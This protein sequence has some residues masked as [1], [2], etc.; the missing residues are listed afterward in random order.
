MI[1][2]DTSTMPIPGIN[3]NPISGKTPVTK[4][5]TGQSARAVRG[6]Q[7]VISSADTVELESVDHPGKDGE[8]KQRPK[9]P[10]REDRGINAPPPRKIDIK[11]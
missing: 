4:P 7:G 6:K 9:Q 3:F 2:V 11:G 5:R 8:Q 10:P 1:G